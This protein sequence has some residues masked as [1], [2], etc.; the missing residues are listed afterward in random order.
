MKRT[1]ALAATV[2]I[3]LVLPML[4]TCGSEDGVLGD[5]IGACAGVY[6]G[7]SGGIGGTAPTVRVEV[8][9][10]AIFFA[11]FY[12]SCRGVYPDG[13]GCGATVT[14]FNPRV[15]GAIGGNCQFTVALSEPL[16]GVPTDLKIHGSL[17]AATCKVSGTYE[18]DHG[19]CCRD[20]GSWSATRK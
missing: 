8:S 19:T 15:S 4:L 20:S 14:G 5:C 10:G 13:R 9:D 11:D 3:L 6:A 2:V 17:D 1:H 7:R 18:F 16:D 12:C